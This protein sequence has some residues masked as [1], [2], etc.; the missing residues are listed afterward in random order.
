[1]RLAVMR[2]E[3]VKSIG[4]LVNRLRHATREVP[5]AHAD[6]SRRGLNEQQLGPDTAD[7]VV[8]AM[9][10]RWPAKR[11]KDAVL[12]VE[13]VMSASK[14]WWDAAT[15]QQQEDFVRSSLEWL[16]SKYGAENVVYSVLHRD[17]QTPHLSVFVVPERDG[18]LQA[19]NFIG[20]DVQMRQDQSTYAKAIAHLGIERGVERS[21]A[22]HVKPS[23]F[24]AQLQKAERFRE[25]DLQKFML[26]LDVPAPKA[27]DRV[28]PEKYAHRVVAAVLAPFTKMLV[29]QQQQITLQKK[30][31]EAL[32]E[33]AKGVEKR[34]GTFFELLD[35]MPQPAQKKRAKAVLKAL[36]GDI[37]AEKKTK[38]EKDAASLAEH[39]K[40][41][42]VLSEKMML[43]QPK[44][45]KAKAV[46]TVDNWLTSGDPADE[47][48]L[49][50]LCAAVVPDAQKTGAAVTM[51]FEQPAP[52][53]S[54]GN[55]IDDGPK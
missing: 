2:A 38:K 53:K 25:R 30:R 22:V 7:A 33:T 14:D 49:L 41:V 51:L 8:G 27:M 23:E 6:A 17:E 4:E 40:N 13:Y 50:D 19:K 29:A 9:R 54:S 42:H 5:P 46:E 34:Y 36:A 55:G 39:E 15:P 20:N 31:I 11:R 16:E 12:A 37:Q 26:E 10:L 44:M 24:Y 32:T 48:K 43:L 3:K 18:R 21:A 35:A 45:T 52:K 47:K 1:M 28:N